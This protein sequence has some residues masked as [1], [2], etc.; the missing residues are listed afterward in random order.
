MVRRQILE[1]ANVCI[2]IFL[3]PL[4]QYLGI[5]LLGRHG[6]GPHSTSYSALALVCWAVVASGFRWGMY[7]YQINVH[8][9]GG[10]FLW[11]SFGGLFFG[12]QCWPRH[13]REG[14]NVDVTLA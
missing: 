9:S 7:F 1:S 5:D 13:G 2:C 14:D 10:L 8:V 12:G 6:N 11:P 4:L 3:Q